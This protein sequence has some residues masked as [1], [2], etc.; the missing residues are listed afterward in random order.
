MSRGEEVMAYPLMRCRCGRN[1]EKQEYGWRRTC[2]CEPNFAYYSNVAPT[3]EDYKA[4]HQL[5][6]KFVKRDASGNYLYGLVK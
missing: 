2:G 5:T 6:G 4:W 3:P 1:M